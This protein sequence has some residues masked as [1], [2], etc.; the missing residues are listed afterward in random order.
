ML[1]LGKEKKKDL[2]EN[3]FKCQTESH[4]F[5]CMGVQLFC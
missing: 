3:N 5:L 2:S 4:T 1:K